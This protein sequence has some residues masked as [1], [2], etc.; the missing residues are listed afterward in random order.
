[1]KLTSIEGS[2]NADLHDIVHALEHKGQV[3]FVHVSQADAAR[4]R[5]RAET[6]KGREV[7]IVLP[8]SAS[9]KDGAVVHLSEDLAIVLRVDTGARMVLVP[10]DI[11][12]AM[13]LGHWC[14]NLHW[15]VEFNAGSMSVQLDGPEGQ[16]RARLQDL[17]SLADF[18]IDE[19]AS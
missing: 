15:K 16:Y 12:S 3:E 18:H 13:R 7:Q 17:E 4:K 11:Q 1:M 14:G 9:I 6:D 19:S 2:F 10:H 8:R 5:L